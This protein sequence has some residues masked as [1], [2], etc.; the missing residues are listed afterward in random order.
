MKSDINNIIPEL[1]YPTVEPDTIKLSD[2]QIVNFI[3]SHQIFVKK[4]T[5]NKQYYLGNNTRRQTSLDKSA[6]NNNI[7]VPYARTMTK[8]VKGYM[9]KAGYTNYSN[10]KDN[11][12]FFE[13]LKEVYKLNYEDL[14][15]GEIGEN[16]SK[17]GVAFTLLYLREDDQGKPIPS[18][19]SLN[20]IEIIPVYENSF[21][22]SL[23]CAIR[24]YQIDEAINEAEKDDYTKIYNIEIYYKN[25]T[26][27]LQL[28]ANDSFEKTSITILDENLENFFFDVP[29][30]VYPNNEEYTSD[31]EPVQSLIDLYDKMISDMANE[32]DRFATA[33]LI[34]KEYVLGGNPEEAKIK[35]D[36]MKELRV[37][38]I[39]ADGEIKFL[40]KEIPVEFFREVR[41]MLQEDITYHSGIPDFRNET[42]GTQSS[43]IA[44]KY[45]L[46][47]LENLCSDKETYFKIGKEREI[48]LINNYYTFKGNFDP[49][50]YRNIVITMKRNLPNNITEEVDNYKKV[51]PDGGI[52]SKKTALSILSFVEDAETE[53]DEI[54]KEKQE[55]IDTM[56]ELDFNSDPASNTPEETPQADNVDTNTNE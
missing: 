16:Q 12:P 3:K 9:Y 41:T 53:A 4:F 24:Y 38:E 26:D 55:R 23:F 48:K 8:T 39:G 15:N 13:V 42:F 46:L 35:L 6:P 52:L 30:C 43:G 40:T 28:K 50:S 1:S 20:P 44:I 29:L 25:V 7:H 34:M 36:R 22:K 17:F 11:D 32:Q 10:V 54:A 47:G 19:Y 18:I 27:K 33:Y 45:K 51:D 37:F 56:A 14:L 21:Q 2:S 31:Y 49:L 5:S